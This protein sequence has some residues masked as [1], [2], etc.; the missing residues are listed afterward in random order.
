[1]MSPLDIAFLSENKDQIRSIMASEYMPQHERVHLT[2]YYCSQGH[3]SFF[4]SQ[5]FELLKTTTPE[6]MLLLYK[7]FGTAP[8]ILL[9]YVHSLYVHSSVDQKYLLSLLSKLFS[10][11]KC[12]TPISTLSDKEYH[13]LAVLTLNLAMEEG[14]YSLAQ[15]LLTTTRC[16]IAL[17]THATEFAQYLLSYPTADYDLTTKL[18]LKIMDQGL[19]SGFD[20]FRFLH[21]CRSQTDSLGYRFDSLCQSLD[22]YIIGLDIPTSGSYLHIP[23]HL[24]AYCLERLCETKISAQGVAMCKSLVK[25]F[26]DYSM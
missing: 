4:E 1:M 5:I 9:M 12:Q 11:D 24:I 18:G 19:N 6:D 20:L 15:G 10:D 22:E 7:K 25:E 13:F 26:R 17:G 23:Q 2:E 21:E 3:P 14:N 16:E 8:I